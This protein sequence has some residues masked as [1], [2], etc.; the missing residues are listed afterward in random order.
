MSEAQKGKAC[1]ESR[2]CRKRQKSRKGEN[3]G[4]PQ[5]VALAVDYRNKC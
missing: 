1:T 5:A 4:Q 3:K 2:D